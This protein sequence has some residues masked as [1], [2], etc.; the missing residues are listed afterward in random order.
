MLSKL[1]R[2]CLALLATLPSLSVLADDSTV[3][4]KH[5]F[6]DQ[7]GFSADV[8]PFLRKH[9]VRCHGPDAQEGG[10]RVDQLALDLSQRHIAESWNELLDRVNSGEM[11]PEGEAVPKPSELSQAT[12]WIS[13]QLQAATRLAQSTGGQIV[14]RRLNRAEYNNTIRD[15]IGIDYEPAANFPED[16]PAFGFDN[17]GNALSISPLHFEKYLAAARDIVDRAIVT[18]EPPESALWHIEVEQAHPSNQFE[19][20]DS[21]GKSE[22]WTRDPHHQRHR[23]L[24]KGGGTKVEDGWLVQKGN[25]HEEAAGFRWFRI[26]QSGTYIVRIR[27]AARIPTRDEVVASIQQIRWQH[28]ERDL[29]QENKTADEIA[30]QKEAWL[31]EEWPEILQN[32]QSKFYYNY[33][34]PRL[35]IVDGDGVVVDE[36]NVETPLEKPRTYEIRHQFRES[37]GKDLATIA[38]ENSYVVPPEVDNHWFVHSSE[39]ARPELW[40]D[41]VELEGPHVDAWPPSSHQRLL[42]DS[43][44]REDE[45]RYARQVL[46][47]FMTRAYRRPVGDDELQQMFE[48]FQQARANAASLEEAIKLPLTATLCSP[49]FLYLVEPT[50]DARRRELDNYELATRLSY[51]LWSSLPDDELFALAQSGQLS[52][53]EVLRRQANRMLEDVKSREFV[54]NFAGQW[55]GLREVGANPPSR[56]LFSRYDDHLQESMVRESEAFFAEILDHDLDVMNFVAS[57]F[58][59]INN[60]LARFYE[61][62]G[63]TDDQMKKVRVGS[64]HHRGGLLTQASV[65]TT[66]SNGTRTSPVIRGKWILENLLGD[67]PPPPPPDAGDITPKVPGI[68]K[69]TV[70]TRLEHHRQI[71]ACA[72]CH[73]KI[74]PLGFALENFAADGRWREREGFGYKGRVRSGD[75]LIDASGRLPNGTKFE[76]FEEFRNI[77][78]EKEDEFLRCFV[79]KLTTYALGRGIEFS[80]QADLRQFVHNM[81]NNGRTI[82]GLIGDIVSSRMFLTK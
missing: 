44:N 52:R 47:Q 7:P 2:N 12:G 9:C 55:L 69:A 32:A 72:S 34:S 79:E 77:L 63:V 25:R 59:T 64:Q 22:L 10:F 45:P 51:F 30:V 11:P 62:P 1:A 14:L 16:P 68:D 42:P 40:I 26:P 29:Q 81:Q 66:T 37:A 60:R 43:P 23:Y 54:R 48:L 78:L 80:D 33:G 71:P 4:T 6:G 18:G 31:K 56:E 28:V 61:I 27:A 76:S 82:R 41:W 17:I 57:D 5:R 70:R 74:D 65:L 58:V 35:K 67:P 19:G 53:P 3:G 8:E 15:L 73:A 38:I 46:E 50:E 24:I 21:A 75:P 39:F 36:F 49:H 20:R 13:R